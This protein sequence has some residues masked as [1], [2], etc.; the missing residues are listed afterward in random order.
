[1]GTGNSSNN[2]C[3][4]AV[5]A[6]VNL[7]PF[8]DY[9]GKKLFVDLMLLV[10]QSN[11]V[12]GTGSGS[13]RNASST[14]NVKSIIPTSSI[15]AESTQ[16][17]LYGQIQSWAMGRMYYAKQY[18]AKDEIFARF[19]TSDIIVPLVQTHIRSILSIFPPLISLLSISTSRAVVISSLELWR[20]LIDCTCLTTTK[21]SKPDNNEDSSS[22]SASPS[23]NYG[24]NDDGMVSTVPPR[25][26]GGSSLHNDADQN[27]II[28][29]INP[30]FIHTP[31]VVF[32]QLTRLLWIPR[33]GPDS[34]EYVDPRMNMVTRVS[35]LKLMGGY[36]SS[37]DYEVRDRA[38]EVLVKLTSLDLDCLKRRVGMRR[39]CLLLLSLKMIFVGSAK[40]PKS[41]SVSFFR[42][43]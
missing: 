6:L 32:Y 10:V 25:V 4:H 3:L 16:K 34:Y 42:R 39:V 37:V 23:P 11:G 2:I 38:L 13:G 41:S 33:L 20:E 5:Q 1:L 14:L 43:K 18:D 31:D 27:E 9:T 26:I 21:I 7:V 15:S 30:I 12:D 22:P 36:D 8:L 28:L 17:Q 35:A 24:T 40:L 19:P 29:T